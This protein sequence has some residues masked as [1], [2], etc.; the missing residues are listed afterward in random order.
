MFFLSTVV[1]AERT[2]EQ[3]I[4][5]FSATDEHCGAA[6]CT[7]CAMAGPVPWMTRISPELL[8]HP[9]LLPSSFVPRSLSSAEVGLRRRWM[10][11][12]LCYGSEI[13]LSLPLGSHHSMP[14]AGGSG[15]NCLQHA[16]GKEETQTSCIGYLQISKGHARGHCLAC[17][18]QVCW[19]PPDRVISTHFYTHFTRICFFIALLKSHFCSSGSSRAKAKPHTVHQVEAPYTKSSRRR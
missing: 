17:M 1:K 3:H 9:S 11:A 19:S 13:T 2:S 6:L 7:L 14:W 12:Q 18:T 15:I 4:A 5:S 16:F 8:S 10:E